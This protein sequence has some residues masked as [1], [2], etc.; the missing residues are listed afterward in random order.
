MRAIFCLD[1]DLGTAK[2]RVVGSRKVFN[3][4][5][6]NLNWHSL[7]RLFLFASRDFCFEVALPFFLRSSS[8]EKHGTDFLFSAP[9]D[10]NIGVICGDKGF[11]VNLNSGGGCGRLA[12]EHVIVGAL[13]GVYI[14]LYDE[15]HLWTPR[16]VT[17][18][19]NQRFPNKYACILRGLINCIPTSNAWAAMTCRQRLTTST[20][21]T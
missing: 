9:D 3:M 17:G 11:C 10:C 19:L 15:G 6:K 21:L 4:A 14:L 12:V 20:C 5:N 1:C 7:A 16:L 18:P 8:C 2:A 13:L